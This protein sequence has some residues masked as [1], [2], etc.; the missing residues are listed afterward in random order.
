MNEELNDAAPDS[1]NT[2]YPG[3]LENKTDTHPH[4]LSAYD[5]HKVLGAYVQVPNGLLS[6]QHG[7]ACSMDWEGENPMPLGISFILVGG[8]KLWKKR[9]VDAPP[10]AFCKKSSDMICHR[11]DEM[12]TQVALGW[13]IWGALY[14]GSHQGFRQ[15]SGTL[16]QPQWR[17]SQLEQ[18][19]RPGRSLSL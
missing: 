19:Y 12:C 5:I 13:C 6:F 4:C 18:F 7:F 14:I 17:F 8:N 10:N 3:L 15:L 9:E 2:W 11:T 1:M 16:S